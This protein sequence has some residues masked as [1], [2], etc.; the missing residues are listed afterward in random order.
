MQPPGHWNTFAQFVSQRDNLDLDAQVK[1]FFIMTNAVFD[2][3]IAAWETKRFYNSERPITAIHFLFAGKQVRA[4]GGPY[5]GAQVIQGQN[6]RPYQIATIVTPAFPEYNSGHSTFSASA[7]EILKRFTGS[8]RF[9]A[10]QLIKAGTAPFELG[11]VPA[12]DIT[13]SWATFSNA[14]DQA[15]MSRRYGG[16]HFEQGDLMGR[17]MGRQVAGVVWDKAQ[18]YI[19]GT[20]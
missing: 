9:G 2:A 6:W 5:Q 12:K 7:A 20:P 8:D 3:G 17:A 10:S 1:L 15:G 16:I 13:L 18:A 11:Q 4:W 19:H 14:A